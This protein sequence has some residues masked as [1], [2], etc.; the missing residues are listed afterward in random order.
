MIR[1][2]RVY[3]DY[4]A[5]TPVSKNVQK[6]MGPFWDRQ[7]ANPS[8]I[9]KEGVEAGRAVLHART[10][11][12]EALSV[13]RDE[14][15]FTGSATESLNL[16]LTGV[17]DR[18]QSDHPGR[19]VSVVVSAIEHMAIYENAQRWKSRGVDVRILPVDTK[20]I[21]DLAILPALITENTIFVS[22]MYANNEIGTIQPIREIAKIVREKRKQFYATD[23]DTLSYPYLHTDACQATNYLEI[24]VPK[25]GVDMLT[26]NAAK[27][28]GPKGIALLYVRR[29]VALD[30]IIVGGGQ[31]HGLRAGTENVP[32][33]IGFAEALRETIA[34]KAKESLR[35]QKLRDQLISGL[36]K[37]FSQIIVNGDM[38]MRLPNNLNISL[39]GIDHEQAVLLLDA[40]GVF[41]STKS[42]CNELD[43]ETS[44]VL[45][46]IRIAAHDAK[47][48][49][50]GIRMT[51]GRRTTAQDIKYVLAQFHAIR[52]QLYPL[53]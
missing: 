31:E 44:H 7:F 12:A 19:P 24:A 3:L 49:E 11:I 17:I 35:V 20:G 10:Q 30:P 18:Y 25:L 23:K 53:L 47:S 39:P 52:A 2:K 50:N 33:V 14:I 43:A 9:H 16:A 28:Y 6:A 21:V 36:R 27:I 46:A 51:L 4:A 41:V 26:L 13:H 29:G 5:A 1:K 48:P 15:I 42:A 34:M 37:E 45:Q 38:E 22:V 32:S 8:A 40:H